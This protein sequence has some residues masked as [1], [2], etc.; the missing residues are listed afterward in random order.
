[1]CPLFYNLLSPPT[2]HF[3]ICQPFTPPS[4]LSHFPQLCFCQSYL[5]FP[6]SVL[7]FPHLL[8][9]SFT[10]MAPSYY[11][12]PSVF[13]FT[14]H[15]V[16]GPTTDWV[17]TVC[18]DRSSCL[19]LVLVWNTPCFFGSKAKPLQHPPILPMCELLWERAAGW[20]GGC[21]PILPHHEEGPSCPW[22]LRRREIKDELPPF[23][24][25][26]SA[27]LTFLTFLA[28]PSWPCRYQLSILS[29]CPADYHTP[30][31]PHPCL[32]WW[33]CA[34]VSDLK[35]YIDSQNLYCFS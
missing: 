15:T 27:S 2:A 7:Q 6:I 8:F 20:R 17:A 4:V 29:D 24:P 25:V 28:F 19:H 35:N 33:D 23:R 22:T 9:S 31:C 10:I 26:T 21:G 13:S 16:W 18:Q 30:D 5:V 11:R 3:P 14:P 32:P 12:C 34:S 1:M